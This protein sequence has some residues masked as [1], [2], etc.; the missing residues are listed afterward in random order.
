MT[1]RRRSTTSSSSDGTTAI[2]DDVGMLRTRRPVRTSSTDGSYGS[3]SARILSTVP[4]P[5]PESLKPTQLAS[6]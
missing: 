6:Q 5:P 2:T 3:S 4:R 1:R